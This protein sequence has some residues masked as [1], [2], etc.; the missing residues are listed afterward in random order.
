MR[1]CSRCKTEKPKSEFW[2][3]RSKKHGLSSKCKPCQIELGRAYRAANPHLAK[4]RYWSNRD[5]ERERHLVRKYGIRLSD[6]A[7]MLK[8]QG[9]KC[10]IC[11]KPEPLNKTLDVD[12]CH[13]TKTVRGLLCTSCNRLLG[14]AFDDCDRLLAAVQ[15]LQR[16]SSKPHSK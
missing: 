2:P 10:A 1:T 7:E 3:D 4:N 8:T 9:G 16:N 12:H 14:H 13:K 5:G 11:N 15:Y 6:Y